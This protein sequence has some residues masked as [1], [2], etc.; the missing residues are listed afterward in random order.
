MCTEDVDKYVADDTGRWLGTVLPKRHAR[1][2]VTRNLL[3]R[4]IR[5][6]FE[7]RDACMSRLP[8]GLWLV[9]LHTAFATRE[10]VSAASSALA[11]SV[12][13]EL[14]DLLARRTRAPV[15]HRDRVAAR[16]G[17]SAH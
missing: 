1:R 11:A 7:R 16:R 17:R 2:A 15:P 12:A 13:G 4:Q 14:D 8:A 5:A 3:R 10:F 9:R 6:A